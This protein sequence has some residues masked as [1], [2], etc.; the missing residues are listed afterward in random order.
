MKIL[1]VI[2]GTKFISGTKFI[3]GNLIFLAFRVFFTVWFGMFKFSQVTINWIFN[4]Q[5]MISFMVTTGSLNNQEMTRILKKWRHDFSGKHLHD[6]YCMDIIWCLC[7][8]QN[9]WFC[10]ASLRL[11][12][13][14]LFECKGPW[15]LKTHKLPCVE[16]K[17]TKL[18]WGST[19]YSVV[20]F[21][22][23]LFLCLLF[24]VFNNLCTHI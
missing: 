24:S 2:F 3:W 21:F 20:K 11:C 9:S 23:I 22:F 19:I 8:G 1:L 10:K 12:Y 16:Q 14:S 15:M 18:D 17:I 13:V 7:G 6:R 4:S 5:G